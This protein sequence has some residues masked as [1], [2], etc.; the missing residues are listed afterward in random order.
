MYNLHNSTQLTPTNL[1][2][3]LY[4]EK[5]QAEEAKSEQLEEKIKTMESVQA[6]F[7]TEKRHLENLN[8]IIQEKFQ[9]MNKLC[10]EK[11]NALQQKLD[12]KEVEQCVSEITAAGPKQW[13]H[14][15]KRKI[16]DIADENK[17]TQNVLKNQIAYHEK[18]AQENW[19][20]ACA[21]VRSLVLQRKEVHS[22]CDE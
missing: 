20:I 18:K 6:S 16:Q 15:C 5:L 9:M 22:L 10:Q 2:E 21:S 3:K 13:V 7:D 8:N 17:K 14:T 19:I 4:L 11:D 12:Q 1:E